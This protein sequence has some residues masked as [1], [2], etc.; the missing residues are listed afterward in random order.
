MAGICRLQ[1]LPDTNKSESYCLVVIEQSFYPS[2]NNQPQPH[3]EKGTHQKN[4][5][6][7]AAR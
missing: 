4:H 1:K 6:P 2:A 5:D 7:R 3:P